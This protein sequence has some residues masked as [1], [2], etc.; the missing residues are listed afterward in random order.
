MVFWLKQRT[1]NREVKDVVIKLKMGPN[2]AN[3]SRLMGSNV[4]KGGKMGTLK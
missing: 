2:K 1:H 4:A 3:W